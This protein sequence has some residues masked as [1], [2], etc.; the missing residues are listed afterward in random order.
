MGQMDIM[1]RVGTP[2]GTQ[3]GLTQ[4][5]ISRAMEE[6]SK[7][8]LEANS[9]ILSNGNRLYGVVLTLINT[10]IRNLIITSPGLR[11]PLFFLSF[12]S[13]YRS[14]LTSACSLFRLFGSDLKLSFRITLSLHL[15]AALLIFSGPSFMPDHSFPY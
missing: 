5:R 11:N 7:W 14:C 8:L 3:A 2:Q 12:L 10:S 13:H 15:H 4:L 1:K 6:K 9:I